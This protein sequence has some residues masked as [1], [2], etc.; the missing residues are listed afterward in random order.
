MTR[1]AWFKI[2]ASDDADWFDMGPDGKTR[3]GTL[4]RTKRAR[5]A[6]LEKKRAEL[7]VQAEDRSGPASRTACW[8]IPATQ[9]PDLTRT[10]PAGARG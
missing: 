8:R 7:A 2:L 1:E 3:E 4:T 9:R 10:F 6:E 5:I